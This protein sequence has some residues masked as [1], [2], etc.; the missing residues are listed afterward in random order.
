[1]QNFKNVQFQIITFAPILCNMRKF[2]FWSTHKANMCS[3]GFRLFHTAPSVPHYASKYG[4]C[5][6]IINVVLISGHTL[7]Y[8]QGG[9][10]SL[11]YFICMS[12]SFITNVSWQWEKSIKNI[13]FL[14]SLKF[15]VKQFRETVS[16]ILFQETIIF[17]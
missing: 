17:S 16:S 9:W 15:F 14:I 5:R 11:V 6:H 7:K 3:Y 10:F 1:M 4:C 12:G 13:T 2:W 8:K